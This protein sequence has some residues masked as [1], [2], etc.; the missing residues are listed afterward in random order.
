MRRRD[1]GWPTGAKDPMRARGWHR[2]VG[3]VPRTG[4]TGIENKK[5]PAPEKNAVIVRIAVEIAM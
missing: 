2:M 5:G 1:G 4:Y 3:F